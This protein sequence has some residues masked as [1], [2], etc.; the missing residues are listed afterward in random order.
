MASAFPVGAKFLENFNHELTPMNTNKEDQ[1]RVYSCLF[2]VSTYGETD[3]VK[4]A[5]FRHF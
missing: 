4:T 3:A 1:I 2:V 5:N